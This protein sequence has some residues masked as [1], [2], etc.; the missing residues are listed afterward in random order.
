MTSAN[1]AELE[2]MLPD[3]LD[4]NMLT[5]QDWSNLWTIR[6]DRDRVI[7]YCDNILFD[8]EDA[9]EELRRPLEEFFNKVM[10]ES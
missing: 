10:R 2:G 5:D 7:H 4:V 3:N 1:K 8:Y 9:M 6:N